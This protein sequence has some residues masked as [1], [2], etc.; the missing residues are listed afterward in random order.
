MKAIEEFLSEL[1]S[2]DIKL[3]VDGERLRCS[4]PEGTLTSSLRVELQQ[5]KGEI[6]AFLQKANLGSSSII[7]SIVPVSREGKLP[8]SFAQRRLWFLQQFEP[9]SGFYNI[10]VAVHFSGRL[11]QSALEQ[12]LNYMIRRHEALR[13][14]FITKAGQATQVI[15]PE[16]CLKLQIIDLQHLGETEQQL[17]C[18]KLIATEAVRP[19][20]LAEDLLVRAT[21]LNLT[22]KEHVLLLVIHHI[23]SDGW[24]TGIVVKELAAVYNAVCN[25]E[26]INLSEL[27]IQ[28]ADFAVWQQQYLAGEALASQQAYWQQQL[29]T[30]PALLELPT[31]HPRPAI[32]TYKGATQTFILSQELTSALVSLSQ[33]QGVTL[34]MTLLAAYQTL[35]YRYSGQTDICVGTPIANRNHSEIEGLIGLFANTLVLRNNLSGNPSFADLLLHVREVALGAYAHQDLPFEQLVEALQPERSLSYTPLFQVMFVLQNAPMPELCLDELTLSPWPLSNSTAKFDLT[36]T[37]EDT[38]TGLSGSIEYNTDLF[39]ESTIVRMAQ[40]Y[41]NL[42]NAVVANPQQKLSDLAILSTNEQHQ[43]LVE[44]NNTLSEYSK[45]VCMHQ[46]FE[47]QVEKTPAAVAVSFD[48]EQL[49]YRE[50][51]AKANQLAHHLRSLGVRPEVLVGICTQRS[52]QMLVGLLAVLKAGGAYVPVDPNYP[53]ERLEYILADSQVSVVLTQQHLV[54]QLAIADADVVELEA[55]W[56]HY[57]SSNPTSDVL[58]ENIAYAIYTSGSTGKPKGVQIRHSAV[59]NFLSSMSREPGL[60]SEDVLVALTTITF[61]IAALELFLPLTVGGRV[62][63]SPEV[64]VDGGQS[65]AA[66]ASTASVMQ[67][68]P[69]TWR[70][71]MQAGFSCAQELKILCGGEALSRELANQLLERAG[72]LWN[73]YGPTETTIWSAVSQVQATSGLVSI[74]TAIANTQFYILDAYLQPVPVG[75]PGELHIGGDGLARGYLSR[76]ELTAEKFIPNPFGEPGSRLYKTGDLVRYQPNGHL[77]YFGRI[78][79]QVKIRGFRMELGEIEAVLAQHLDVQQTVVVAKADD[80]G[81]K[82]LVAYIVPDTHQNAPAISELRSFCKQQ[83]PEYMLPSYFVTLDALPLTPNGKVDRKALP[84]A[85]SSSESEN[86]VAPTTPT[87]ELLA[88][89]WASVLGVERVGIHD[90]FFELGGH[91]LLATQLMS[92]LVSTFSVELPLRNLFEFPTVATLGE[93]IRTAQNQGETLQTPAIVPVARVEQMPLSFAQTRL[94]FL[95]QFEPDNGFYNISIAVRLSGHLNQSAL[96]QSLNY[97][98]SR[99]EGLRTNFVSIAGQ[100]TQVIHQQRCLKLQVVDLQHLDETQQQ[101]SLEQLLA[102]EAVQP[103]ELANDLLTRATLLQLQPEEQVLSVVIHHIV[104]DGWSMGVLVQELAVVYT[105]ICNDEAIA[106]AQL[107]IQYADFAVWQQEYLAGEILAQQHSYWQQQ[108]LG[109]PVLLELP[110]DHPRPAIQTYR[111]ATKAFTL[112]SSLTSALVSLSHEQGVTLFM[113]LLAAYQTLLYRYSGQTDICVGTPIANRNH[114]EIEGLIGLF[115]NTL[116]LRNNLSGNP[117]FRD[118]LVQVREVALGA[119]AHQDLPFEQLVEALQPERSLS[120]T[121]LFQVMFVLQNAPMPELCL[122]DL[123]LLPLPISGSTA[124]FDLTL[125]LEQTSSGLSGSIEYNTDLFDE[126]TI[127]RMAQHYENLLNAVVANPQQKLSELAILTAAEKHQILVEWNNTLSEYSKDV[128]MHQLFEQQ[129]EKTPAA[130]AVSFDSEQ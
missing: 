21:L 115:V 34:F 125:S 4:A 53:T 60:V 9:E 67:G 116:V 87:Q 103:F 89:I 104:S 65:T 82:H 31:D 112:S 47:Q 64:M 107:P 8:L 118:L 15:H 32:Q 71:L 20:D 1:G 11:N 109:A 130:V 5:R 92:R 6:L 2:L 3:W 120:H 14:N 49:T 30:A 44:W 56:S 22:P 122:S 54:S 74:G 113:T 68:T 45:D 42:L 66:L 88:N 78:D 48:S 36:L 27:P 46:L 114:S 23:V 55:D 40:H 69:A 105:A 101:I 25:N 17:S 128:C 127:V 81:N 76:P 91:S 10:S 16:R 29:A 126:S 28:Y 97:I 110:T 108:L 80:A 117:S 12:S 62:V 83:L 63:I 111:G 72:S 37:L 33:R 19:F 94:W 51:N 35:L 24:S 70:L 124:K 41:E 59:V 61:D 39:D 121:P 73:M 75:V 90:N 58:G 93:S 123:T 7:E 96:E 102:S 119:Y 13:T 77:E 43:I 18:Q 86:F 50:L 57:N 95:A 79:H 84:E 100:P 106:L 99:H 52:T 129:V 85:S 38:S 98:I 26:P